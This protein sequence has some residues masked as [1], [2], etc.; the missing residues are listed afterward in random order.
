M[1]IVLPGS[2][3]YLATMHTASQETAN[4]LKKI[5]GAFAAYD[6]RRGVGHHAGLADVKKT[7]GDR[8]TGTEV[9]F[10]TVRNPYDV[11]TAWFTRNQGHYQ[12][13]ML[14]ENQGKEGT[15]RQFL[16]LWLAMD[17]LPYMKKKRIFYHADDVRV[18]LRF[19]TLQAQLNSL[20]RKTPGAPAHVPLEIPPE[21]GD[22][23][24]T[25]YDDALYAFVNENFTEDFVKFGYSFIWSS[26]QLV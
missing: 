12:M 18:T 5:D 16:E 21:E 10:T 23:W 14:E 24:S 20:M 3:I 11:L 9:V 22:H 15:F 1:A 25:Y 13:R 7:C 26:K 2:F 4:A 8:L 19:E 6:K 17:V